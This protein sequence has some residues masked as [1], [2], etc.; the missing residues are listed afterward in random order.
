[1]TG[2]VH[3]AIS[4]GDIDN[5]GNLDLVATG[6]S[7]GGYETCIVDEARVY[8]NNGT[9]L[10]EN[11]TWQQ[12]LTGVGW[13][14]IVLGDIDNDGDLDL[15]ISGSDDGT[16]GF[17]VKVYINNGTIL[18]ENITWQQNLSG[19]DAFSGA[20]ALGDIDNDGD[21]DLALVGAYPSADNGIYINNGSAFVKNSIWLESLPFVGYGVDDGAHV[22]LGD[23]DNDGDL[24]LLMIG[25]RGT[26]FYRRAYINNGTSLVENSIWETNFR[27][28]GEAQH[29]IAFGNWNNDLYLDFA[30]IGL[31]AGD[32]FYIFHNNGTNFI[33]NETEATQGHCCLAGYY[34]GSIAWGDYDNDGD[35]DIVA[36]GLEAG[37]SR[38]YEN[39]ITN[40]YNVIFYEDVVAHSNI[41]NNIVQGHLAWGDLD[42]DND[43]DLIVT[44]SDSGAISKVYINNNTVSNTQPT[45][46]TGFNSSSLSGQVT[47]NWSQGSDSQTPQSGLYYNL[48]L[49]TTSVGN[50]IVSGVYGGGDGNGYFGN[51]MQRRRINL[52]GS[53]LQP[54]TTYYWSVQTIDTALNASS[55][56]DEQSFT[57]GSDVTNPI[58]TLNK[59]DNGNYS[60]VREIVFNVN[61]YDNIDLA[62][63]SLYGDWTGSWLLNETNSSG[64]NNTNYVFT[65]N[66]SGEGVYYWK[67]HSCD[68]SSNCIY[69]SIRSFSVDLNYPDVTLIT[70][71]NG[72]SWTSSSTVTFY[73]NVS[74]IAIAN[75]SLIINGSV[76]QNDTSIIVNTTQPFTKSMSNNYYT[77]QV[78]CTDNLAR[79]NNSET[80]TL[81]VSYTA[82]VNG[83]GG[84]GGGST[85]E[86]VC[87]NGICETGENYINCPADCKAPEPE[88]VENWTCSEW[89][90]CVNGSQSRNCTDI[91]DCGTK[92]YRPKLTKKCEVGG[93]GEIEEGR[94]FGWKIMIISGV[95]IIIAVVIVLIL[96]GERDWK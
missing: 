40:P 90:E 86:A 58:I 29:S 13:S 22:A 19:V 23:I 11:Q 95:V 45:A 92:T 68:N 18:Q 52:S 49:G 54:G 66:M 53:W 41:S 81:T 35:L 10:Q 88:C 82:P 2:V 31:V 36:I 78:N 64:I 26:N 7:S 48:R 94:K 65:K 79:E 46:P 39:G 61:A 9:T 57:T 93:E 32:H 73:Y 72:S 5:D 67:I 38:V 27:A 43:L 87:G 74:D 16:N 34:D 89:S 21:L 42:N 59:P 76:A 6:C 15:V 33:V 71:I 12:N 8:I 85:D 69:S 62:N 44:G 20:I 75:C 55:W 51:M 80:R 14:S 17:D 25:G 91:N 37:G 28:F 47:L 3:G 1:M 50:Q 30:C 56:S 77:W 63:V 84:G 60:G 96:K 70:P 83:G 4:L 24:D